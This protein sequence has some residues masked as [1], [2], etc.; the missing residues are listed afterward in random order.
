MGDWIAP[1]WDERSV[2]E[3]YGDAL[4]GKGHDGD[5]SGRST[6]KRGFAV[7]MR[8][9]VLE[10]PVLGIHARLSNVGAQLGSLSVL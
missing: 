4:G 8:N 2:L 10:E 5:L 9:T 3:A 1:N 6:N 7:A